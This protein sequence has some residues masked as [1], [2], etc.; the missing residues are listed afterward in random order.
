VVNI[1]G[2]GYCFV[3]PLSRTAAPN[4]TTV[5]DGVAGLPHNLPTRSGRII[6]RD[7]IIQTTAAQLLE[8]RLVTIV[9]PGGI[10]KTT[11]AIAVADMLLANFRNAVFFVDLAPLEDPLLVPSALASVLGLIVQSENRFRCE[12][13]RGGIPGIWTP[14]G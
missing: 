9:G 6:G 8:E 10:G 12:L 11:V 13:S 1:P 4:G 5:L 14:V 2:R 7:A 3:A